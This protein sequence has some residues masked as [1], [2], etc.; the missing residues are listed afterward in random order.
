M[1]FVENLVKLS[2]SEIQHDIHKIYSHSIETLPCKS[3]T[4]HE[5]RVTLRGY[6]FENV[7]ICRKIFSFVVNFVN[8]SKSETQHVIHKIHSHDIET[9]A[10]KSET[11]HGMHIV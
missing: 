5:V 7:T 4:Q 10:S 2:K 11:Q 9:P 3:K 8:S 1:G 6:L